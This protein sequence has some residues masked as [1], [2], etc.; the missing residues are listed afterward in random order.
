MVKLIYLLFLLYYFPAQSALADEIIKEQSLPTSQGKTLNVKSDC[1]NV[2]ITTWSKDEAYI[3]ITGNNNV[4]EQM[5]FNIEEKNGDIYVT[6]K[7]SQGIKTLSNISL[8]IEVSIPEKFNTDIKTAGGDI[9]LGNLTGNVEMK[10]AGGDIVLNNITGNSELKT[11]GGDINIS[12]SEGSIEAKTAGG[13][14]N[15]SGSKGSIDAKTAGG[16]I[17]VKYTG[18]N[19]GIDLSTAGGNVKLYLPEN[20]SANIDFKTSA[21]EISLDFEY[22]GKFNKSKTKINGKINNGG[23]LISCKTSGGNIVLEKIK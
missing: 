22:T 2:N 19:K 14:I 6:V 8:K 7:K 9:S 12:G 21:G 18:E 13:D 3:K 4:K 1:G 16:D 15:I 20:F 5:E 10:T 23:E 11:A 17:T